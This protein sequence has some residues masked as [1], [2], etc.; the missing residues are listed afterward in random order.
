MDKLKVL[1]LSVGVGLMSV[2]VYA[3]AAPQQIQGKV[4][5]IILTDDCPAQGVCSA[6]VG[7]AVN[8]GSSGQRLGESMTAEGRGRIVTFH[9]RPDAEIMRDGQA[10]LLPQLAV[11]DFVSIPKYDQITTAMPT[12][13]QILLFD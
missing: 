7:L 5:S 8:I 9:V 12:A 4:V 11:G 10:I 6:N 13:Q 2:G 3:G 1:S